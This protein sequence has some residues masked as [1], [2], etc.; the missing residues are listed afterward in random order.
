MRLSRRKATVALRAHSALATAAVAHTMHSSC[1]APIAAEQ[2]RLAARAD[3]GR[4]HREGAA[5]GLDEGA[6][7]R[8]LRRASASLQ[9]TLQRRGWA[10]MARRLH[11]VCCAL[12]AHICS[13]LPRLPLRSV[14]RLFGCLFFCLFACDWPLQTTPS[15]ARPAPHASSSRGD[16]L[17]AVC[18]A[19][20]RCACAGAPPNPAEP[21]PHKRTAPVR[22][23]RG[24]AEEASTVLL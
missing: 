18:C 24:T 7:G 13:Q 9:G 17:C 21:L 23:R 1:T 10:L 14:L 12:P 6:P 15:M 2:C 19:G 5:G 20:L 4:R 8:F 3:R 16:G 22:M 11:H